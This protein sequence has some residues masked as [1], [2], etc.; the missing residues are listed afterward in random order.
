ME[1]TVNASAALDVGKTTEYRI[2]MRRETL[3]SAAKADMKAAAGARLKALRDGVQ[4]GQE[5]LA[6]KA[7]LPRSEQGKVSLWE[8][9]ER[10]I[11]PRAAW[12]LSAF[13]HEPLASFRPDLYSNVFEDPVH[14]EIYRLTADKDSGFRESVAQMIRIM[15]EQNERR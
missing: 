7:G 8:R 14:E 11:P 9:G 1:L 12:A 4:L 3:D 15:R 6:V 2:G 10:W 5:K 13:F